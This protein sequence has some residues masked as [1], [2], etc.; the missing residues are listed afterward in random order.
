MFGN[1]FFKYVVVIFSMLSI[2]LSIFSVIFKLS[3]IYAICLF[4]VT[5]VLNVVDNVLTT[6]EYNKNIKSIEDEMDKFK[7]DM[8]KGRKK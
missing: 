4:V 2:I 3:P 6:R 5:L 1:S 8:K 7:K